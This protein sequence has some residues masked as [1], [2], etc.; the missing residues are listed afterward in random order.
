MILPNFEEP[1]SNPVECVR[2]HREAVAQLRKAMEALK[3]C[4][5]HSRDYRS[6]ESFGEALRFHESHVASLNG[7][8]SETS[9]VLQHASKYAYGRKR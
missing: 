8:I 1:G 7:V 5:P 3:A 9:W 6:A 2:I 4:Q